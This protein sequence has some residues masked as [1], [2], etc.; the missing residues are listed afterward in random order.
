MAKELPYYKFYTEEWNN[1]DIDLESYAVQ[2]VFISI[3]SWY[4]S[5]ECKVDIKRLRRKF[6]DAVAELETLIEAKIIKVS[7][8]GVVE[9]NFLDEQQ[10]EREKRR[11]RNSI[12]G[13]KGGRSKTQSVTE[14]EP[15]GLP[16]RTQSVSSQKPKA[17]PFR[18]EEKRVEEKRVDNNP[19]CAE[20]S[21]ARGEIILKATGK[22][23]NWLELQRAYL[24][25]LN[26]IRRRHKPTSK[27]FDKLPDK[28][29]DSLRRRF[30]NDGYTLKD[31]KHCIEVA[32]NDEHHIKH[33][34]KWLNPEFFTRQ[35]KI[36]NLLHR[37]IKETTATNLPI[38]IG[39]PLN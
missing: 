16:E 13:A 29:R 15:S 11:E 12:N 14:T 26:E 36:E 28:A 35:D 38:G 9:I 4:W 34:F 22:K 39:G 27:G 37:E 32:F 24:K 31:I 21:P 6:S 33:S 25:I 5:R 18:G 19:L 20:Q 7:Q 1:G 2:G 23:V 8:N 17:K 30:V 10:S 3:C